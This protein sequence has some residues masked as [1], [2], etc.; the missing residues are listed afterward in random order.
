MANRLTDINVTEISGVDRA[1]NKRRFLLLKSEGG[2]EWEMDKAERPMKTEDGKKYPAEAYLY[3][4]DPEKPSTW[5]LRIWEDPEKKVTAAQVG[6]AIAALSPGGFRGNRVDIP[7]DEIPKIKAKLRRLWREVNPDKDESEMPETIKKQGFIARIAEG[8]RNMFKAEGQTFS[9]NIAQYQIGDKMWLAFEAL[10]TAIQNTLADDGLTEAE[11][12]EQVAVSLGQFQEFVMGLVGAATGT[13]IRKI[14]AKI[15]RHRL[16]K[17]KAAYAVLGEILAEVEPDEEGDEMT[18]EE[19]AKV[20]DEAVR[21][22]V[23]R[24]EKLEKPEAEPLKRE[25]VQAMVTEV[26]NKAL[27]PVLQRLEVVEKAKG[28]RKSVDGQDDPDGG[29]KSMWKGIL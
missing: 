8:L 13:G 14:G 23:E 24:L 16:E 7:E 2:D 4:P 25:D 28:V 3:V 6:R 12:A 5:K 18:K 22:V 29:K 21:P 10:R 19:V 9:E 11:K 1:A 27:E 15:A 17:L 20:V 26:V